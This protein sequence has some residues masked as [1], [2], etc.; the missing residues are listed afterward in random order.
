MNA[1][2]RPGSAGR[3]PAA[4]RPSKTE[5]ACPHCGG[6]GYRRGFR[7]GYEYVQKCVCRRT[8]DIEAAKRDAGLPLKF[9]NVTLD[10]KPA[11]GRQP[12][13]PYAGQKRD[14][15]ALESQKRALEA[16]R[17]ARDLYLDAFLYG[18]EV[19]DMFG[20][21]LFGACGRGKTRLA[22]AMLCDLIHA[23]LKDV[24]FIE[25]N[26][27]FKKI[28]FSYNSQELTYQGVLEEL[29][30]AKVLV[31]DDFGVDVSGNLAWVLDNIGYVINER[32]GMNRPTILTCNYWRPLNQTESEVRENPFENH[33]SWEL[34]AAVEKEQTNDELARAR[35]E[36]EQ[37]VSYRL[38]SRIAEMCLEIE[39]LG[40]DYR[41]KINRNRELLLEKQKLDRGS[42]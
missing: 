30:H 32:Y 41:R 37:R 17:Q 3:S 31:I 24:R 29:L 11:D 7:D 2:P 26:E 40:F 12:F 27:L 18:K 14:P 8:A 4:E 21:M 19:A 10:E 39:V 13:K 9:R 36:L 5:A 22:C 16:C 6:A 33:A 35:Q 28:R 34:G 23:G 42:R 1:E 20:V 38:R 25:Y 15:L